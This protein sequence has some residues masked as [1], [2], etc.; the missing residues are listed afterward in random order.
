MT[1]LMN[2]KAL[3][4]VPEECTKPNVSDELSPGAGKFVNLKMQGRQ[5]GCQLPRN[6]LVRVCSRPLIVARC[7]SKFENA[8]LAIQ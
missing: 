4:T 8:L 3:L 1:L 6:S 2:K 5:P 7:P